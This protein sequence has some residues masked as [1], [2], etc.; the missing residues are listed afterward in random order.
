MFLVAVCV[1]VRFAHSGLRPP[2]FFFNTPPFGLAL[3]LVPKGPR[4]YA[5]ELC[6]ALWLFSLRFN[7]PNWVWPLVCTRGLWTYAW[8]QCVC[9]LGFVTAAFGRRLVFNTPPFGLALGLVP[10]EPWAAMWLERAWLSTFLTAALGRRHSFRNGFRPPASFLIP[11]NG[12]AP[13]LCTKWGLGLVLGSV[14]WAPVG[15][16]HS[17]LRPPAFF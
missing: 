14:L 17:G 5:V 12:L 2:A 4:T 16:P 1:L 9:L 8:F 13:W 6:V 3:G 7:T 15:F 10:Q 11:L